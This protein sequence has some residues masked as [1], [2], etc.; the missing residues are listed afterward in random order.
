MIG[1]SPVISN[2]F[3]DKNLQQA[4][5]A[6]GIVSTITISATDLEKLNALFNRLHQ[7]LDDYYFHRFHVGIHSND[8]DYK[9]TVNKEIAE[10]LNPYYEQLFHNCRKLTY[11]FQIKGTGPDSFFP[12]HQDWS[13]VDESK[14]SSATVWLALCDSMIENGGLFAIPGSH[15]YDS[16]PRSGTIPGIMNDAHNELV[17]LMQPY[18]C[19]AGTIMVFDPRVMHYSPA[20]VTNKPRI[21]IVNSILPTHAPVVQYYCQPKVNAGKAELYL[22]PDDFH[23]HFNDFIANQHSQKPNGEKLGE[24]SIYNLERDNV[25][26][27]KDWYSQRKAKPVLQNLLP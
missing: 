17:H 21:S 4:F 16:P 6:D 15:L 19:K 5:E 24:A 7:G 18:L 22:V 14:Y 26:H 27:F 12:I 20:N 8:L 23:L 10:I 11:T 25:A 2:F 1:K 9:T 3:K 13:L